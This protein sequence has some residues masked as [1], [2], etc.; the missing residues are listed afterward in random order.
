M[1]IKRTITIGTKKKSRTRKAKVADPVF[2][3]KPTAGGKHLV[4]VESP[5]KAK[6][7][8]KILGSNYKVLASMGHLRDL[9]ASSLG[10]DIENQFKPEYVNSKDKADVI[11]ALQK[12]A[13]KCSD[14]MLA[15]DPD[16]EGEAIS[17]HLSKL[18]DVNPEDNVRIA[19]HEI[20]SPAIKEAIKHPGPVD[21]HRVDAQQARRVLDRLVGYKLSPW[22]WRQLYKGLSAGRVQSVA[23][24]IIC[25]REQEIRAFVPE[26]YWFVN[27]KFKTLKGEVFSAQYLDDKGKQARLA[28]KEEA[29]AALALIQGKEAE[30]VSVTKRKQQRRARAPYTTSTM[31]Q[32]AVNRLGFSS[33]KTMMLAQMLYEGIELAGHG[34]VGLITY[35]RTD[36]TRISQEMIKQVLPYIESVYGKEYVPETPNIYHK[37]KDAQDAHEAIRPTSLAFSPDVVAS[38]LSRDQLKLYT[39]IWN[40]F[41]ASQMAPQILQNTTAVLS[42]GDA[43]LRASGSHVVFDGFTTVM[44]A[45]SRKKAEGETEKYLPPLEKG[46]T[47]FPISSEG[48][49]H[50][51]TPPPRFTEASLIKTLE[52]KGIGRPSTYAAILDAIQRRKY[53]EKDG[54]QFIP[55]EIG[56]KVTELLKKYF[57]RI[58]D[59]G[60]TADMEQW[61]DKIAEGDATYLQVL[62][63]F[64]G[65]FSKELEEADAHA[66]EERK[67][68]E[69]VSDQVCE[70]CGSPMII[71][72][73]RFGK[74]LACSNYPACH[75]TKSL[76]VNN[77]PE[78]K[79]DKPCEKCGAL[80]VYKNGP[81]GRYLH[82]PECGTNKSI[83]IDT[84]I[85]CPKCGKGHLVKRKSRRGRYFYGC[86]TYPACDMALWNEPVDKF[87][88]VCGHIIVKRVYKNGTE[89]VFCS[90]QE[91]TEYPRRKTKKAS[92]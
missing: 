25:E 49:Q 24:R 71:K 15:T 47:V 64:Y 53:V 21:M 17:W 58:V 44:K 46:E 14:V 78:E 56:F 43:R 22:L 79:S 19:F 2:K 52:E 85:T 72:F 37:A 33:K 90:N 12:E 35:M 51:T 67:N 11:H 29:D 31:Q 26:E 80:M 50:F 74:Y 62:T 75:N 4:V 32:D 59:I 1:S 83:V 65:I 48:E 13:N 82:C 87:C 45:A 30:V 27:A 63:D 28:N 55:T 70:K 36:S 38:S 9:P 77:Q 18:L 76:N 81:Y 69:E 86:S 68:N 20:T 66:E 41:I 10:V 23:V 88:P 73:G 3:R 7:I 54:K 16:R 60:F 6:T 57:G 39:L 91:C 61:L 8:E 40:R 34:H 42:C 5:A 89:K 92:E 84:G